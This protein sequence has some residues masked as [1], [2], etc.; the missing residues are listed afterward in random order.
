MNQEVLLL[1]GQLAEARRKVKEL[2]LE[3]SGLVI[4]IRTNVSPYEDDITKLR[5]PE[6]MASMRRLLTIYHEMTALKKRIADMEE[7]L[8]G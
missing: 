3:A 7:A 1:K 4:A 6:A 8:G 2:D 5:I